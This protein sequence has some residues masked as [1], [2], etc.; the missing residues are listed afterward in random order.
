MGISS[1]G[2]RFDIA[3]YWVNLGLALGKKYMSLKG[4]K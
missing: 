3:V 4:K 1:E 2:S